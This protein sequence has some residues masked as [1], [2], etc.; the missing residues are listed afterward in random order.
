MDEMPLAIP[1]LDSFLFCLFSSE[2]V[3]FHLSPCGFPVPEHAMRTAFKPVTL[4]VP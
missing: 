3:A 4:S 1:K 2:R